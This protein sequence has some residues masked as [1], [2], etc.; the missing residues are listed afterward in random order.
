MTDCV[1]VVARW[2][3][4][5]RHE[6]H[7]RLRLQAESERPHPEPGLTGVLGKRHALRGSPRRL[8][9][10]RSRGRS[11]GAVPRRRAVDSREAPAGGSLGAGD[12]AQD[13][14][15]TNAVTQT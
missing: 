4:P 1:T 13:S 11:R 5:E 3:T 10:D 2:V 12:N 14:G 9:R 6:H 8:G 7:P 15:V